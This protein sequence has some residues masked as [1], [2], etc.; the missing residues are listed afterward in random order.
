[1]VGADNVP[2]GGPFD[3]VF[4][5]MMNGWAGFGCTAESKYGEEKK[6]K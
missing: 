1:L 5:E 4:F 3:P 6:K 2:H